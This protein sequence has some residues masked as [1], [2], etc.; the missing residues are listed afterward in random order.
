MRSFLITDITDSLLVTSM[1]FHVILE[2][3]RATKVFFGAD[4]T[5]HHRVCV[6]R[7]LVNP[8]ELLAGG[9]VATVLLL[10]VQ[11]RTLPSRVFVLNMKVEPNLRQELLLTQQTGKYCRL[12]LGMTGEGVLL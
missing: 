11:H 10:T 6:V 2:C 7:E 9:G 3:H 5:L 8:Q 12:C 1:K 4:R